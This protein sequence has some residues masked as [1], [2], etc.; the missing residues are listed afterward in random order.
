MVYLRGH[1]GRGI[2]LVAKLAGLRS[3]RTRGRDT[4]D[5]N[6]D[7]GLPADARHY[8]AASQVLRDLGV[9]VV[10][11][12]DQQPREGR[13]DARL[14]HHVVGRAAAHAAPQRPQPG[15]TCAPSVTGS[16]HDLLR[17][18]TTDEGALGMSG[19]G[20]TGRSAGRRPRPAGRRRRRVAGTPRSWTVCVAGA[21][22]GLA[23][24]GS[25]TSSVV[26]VPG[27]FELPVGAARARAARYDAVVALGVVIRGGTPHF[28]YVCQPPPTG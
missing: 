24:S 13:R 1:E 21:R 19:D 14:R 9:P 16:G 23:D 2:G 11:A 7:L 12:A 25:R 17:S 10:A 27:A 5:A 6:L 28:D 22:R 3:C 15:P 8:G 4:V 20:R 18:T 26:R